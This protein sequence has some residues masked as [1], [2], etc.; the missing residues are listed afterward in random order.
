[1]NALV[2]G[3]TALTW[4][5]A[6]AIAV[7]SLF[8]SA[9][10]YAV[11]AG[12]AAMSCARGPQFN[13]S[14]SA[15][16]CVDLGKNPNT[17]ECRVGLLATGGG[18]ITFNSYDCSQTCNTR[19]DGQAGMINGTLYSGGV[20]N[21][22]CKMQP[23]L[24]PSPNFSLREGSNPNAISIR[25]GTW[26]AS[27]DICYGDLPPQPEKKDEF[28]HTTSSGHRV[29]KS[30]DRT[31]VSTASGFRTCASDSKNTKGHTETNKSRTEAAA[32]GAPDTPPNP[33]S[34]RPGENWQP[35]GGNTSI[36]N[37]NTG[38]TTNNTNYSNQ[39]TPNGNDPVP[40][41]G[42]G[43][44]AGGSNG[45]GGKED[46]EGE[47]NSASDSGNC[48]A[49]PQCIGD[50]LKCLQ[51][52]YTW[53]VQCNTKGAVITGGDGC[54]DADVPVCAGTTCKAETYASLLQQWRQRCAAKSM[55]DGMAERAGNI[56][57]PDD[58][59]VVDDIWIKEG[60]GTGPKLRQDLIT[61]GGSGPLIPNVSLE[62][63]SWEPPP[64][65]YDAINGVKFLIIAMCTVMAMFIV[66]RNI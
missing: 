22:G 65:F 9:D 10:A 25:S 30:E 6:L 19:L 29:C 14:N 34:N 62:G 12:Q 15:K 8:A 20:C 31:C 63:M 46:G 5:L 16:K 33:P 4:T 44:G 56:S 2:A 28:C 60:T 49:P 55:A 23:N 35:S 64:Q 48:E 32:I 27:G 13:A 11:D 37:N 61:V 36:T 26:K 58:A 59:G 53:K 39:G 52:T 51:L 1:M 50:S 40:G 7:A 18:Y 57:N 3:R 41:D 47:G 43:P 42:S 45:N 21:D 24:S 38:S 66:G 17:G 54:S